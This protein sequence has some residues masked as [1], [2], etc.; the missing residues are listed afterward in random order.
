MAK[1]IEEAK[2]L[3]LKYFFDIAKKDPFNTKNDGEIY[4]SFEMKEYH[5]WKNAFDL[6]ILPNSYTIDEYKEGEVLVGEIC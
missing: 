2:T 4:D 5:K 1:N 6:N 3:L